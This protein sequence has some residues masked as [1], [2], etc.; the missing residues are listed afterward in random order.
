[1]Q[2]DTTL[3][4]YFI[5]GG[6]NTVF[7]YSLFA[8]L[9][10]SGLHYSLAMLCATVAGILFNFKTYGRFVFGSSDSRLIWRFIAVYVILYGLNVGCVSILL[11][12]I[13]NV[14]MANA[15]TLVFIASLGFVLNRSFVYGKS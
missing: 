15:I 13:K 7:G 3:L 11:I 10:W 1:M 2:L 8:L 6:I 4:R 12:Y 5:I 14:Y 9:T